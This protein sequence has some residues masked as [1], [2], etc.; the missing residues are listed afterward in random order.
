MEEALQYA[1]LAVQVAG[2]TGTSMSPRETSFTAAIKRMM[3][4]SNAAAIPAPVIFLLLR[5]EGEWEDGLPPAGY[6]LLQ[7]AAVWDGRELLPQV[8]VPLPANR[9]A[10]FGGSLLHQDLL[11]TGQSH[12][13]Q[14]EGVCHRTISKTS[15]E[16]EEGRFHPSVSVRV[17][18]GHQI[19]TAEISPPCTQFKTQDVQMNLICQHNIICSSI[20]LNF[21]LVFQTQNK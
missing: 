12:S 15:R 4:T 5:S 7:A 2:K 18:V 20:S 13:T 3:A 14:A 21:L 17:L 8:P 19:N 6:D 11:Q 16:Y 1:T 10:P 9:A